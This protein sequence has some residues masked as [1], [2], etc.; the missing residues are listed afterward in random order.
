LCQH[1][2]GHFATKNNYL[3]ALFCRIAARGGIKKANDAIA[4]Q[5]LRIAVHVI[6]DAGT[7]REP[8]SSSAPT[9]NV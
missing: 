2:A 1:R 3:S 5:V 6:R 7:Y 4:H 9:W 8:I